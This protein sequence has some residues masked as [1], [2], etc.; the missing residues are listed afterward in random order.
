MA[1]IKKPPA[2]K[3]VKSP[4]AKAAAKRA[5]NEEAAAAA[6]RPSASPSNRRA[7]PASDEA[8]ARK[9]RCAGDKVV[10]GVLQPCPAAVR[11]AHDDGSVHLEPE[12]IFFQPH[13]PV[14]CEHLLLNLCL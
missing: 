10:T 11:V 6:A 2:K 4:A 7:A 5:R 3:T 13:C 14:E 1:R 12:P 8:P 9:K